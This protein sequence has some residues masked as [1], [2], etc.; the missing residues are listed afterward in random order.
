MMLA[1]LEV[2]GL[3]VL[4]HERSEKMRRGF[5]GSPSPPR[6]SHVWS[7]TQGIGAGSIYWMARDAFRFWRGRGFG[8]AMICH[9]L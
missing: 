6:W 3:A 9:G 5:H 4:E 7:A 2:R 8:F 1:A